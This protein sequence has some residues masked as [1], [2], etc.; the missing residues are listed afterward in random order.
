MRNL[1]LLVQS[2]ELRWR[3]QV[4]DVE[5]PF[6]IHLCRRTVSTLD[7]SDC[8]RR[9]RCSENNYREQKYLTKSV[10]I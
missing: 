4:E 2:E 10:C 6:R 8:R 9:A 1:H 5:I 3:R 7:S